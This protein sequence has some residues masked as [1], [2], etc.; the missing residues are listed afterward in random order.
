MFG[1]AC[2][3]RSTNNLLPDFCPTLRHS[4]GAAIATLAAANR[5]YGAQGSVSNVFTFGSPR[6]GD[7]T[8]ASN[9]KSLGLDELTYR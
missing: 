8:W 6:V 9:Y 1:H 2:C 7:A 5:Q 3:V 4:L